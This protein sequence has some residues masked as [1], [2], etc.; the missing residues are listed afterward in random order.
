MGYPV[1][2]K[3][4]KEWFKNQEAIYTVSKKGLSNL[5]HTSMFIGDNG[6]ELLTVDDKMNIIEFLKTL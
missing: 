5:G 3:I 6:E 1:G 2:K 4:P